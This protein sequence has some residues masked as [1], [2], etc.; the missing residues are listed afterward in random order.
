MGSCEVDGIRVKVM[1]TPGLCD[2]KEKAE[3]T[4]CELAKVSHDLYSSL[5]HKTCVQMAPFFCL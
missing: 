3:S 1:D 5:C 2:P 4:L